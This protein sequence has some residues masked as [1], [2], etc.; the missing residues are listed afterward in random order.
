M[1]RLLAV[2]A[3]LLTLAAPPTIVTV[4][5][6]AFASVTVTALK[7]FGE[8][9]FKPGFTHFPHVNPDAP[10]GGTVTLAESQPG[11][12]DSLNTLIL[13]GVRPRT[14]GLI[15][16]TLMVG[17]GWELDAA[18][19]HL[20]ESVEVADD[21]G[22]AVFT[23]RQG[24]RW[25]DGVPVTAADVVFTW[26]AIQ[27]H[28]APFIKSFLDRIAKVE[29]LDE[30]R[31]RITLNG[32]GEIKPI[33]DFAVTLAPQPRHWWT[34]QGRDISKTTLEAPLGSGPYRIAAVDPGRSITYE[35]VKD[36]WAK[37]LPTAR[38]FYNFDTVKDDF[39]RDDDVM[40]EAFKAG[41]YDFRG[42]YRAQR[43]TTGYDFPA[44]R[45]GRVLKLAVPSELPLGAQGFRLNTRRDKFADV[46]VREALALLF[47]FDWIQKN[48]LYGQYKRTLSNFP[49]S[50]FGAA[51]KPGPDELALLEPYR[52]RLAER[53]L[54][55][56]FT[57]PAG[58]G[59]G[60]NR[61][62][63]REATR[64]FKEAGWEVRN[65]R[66]T[67][68]KT[69][70]GMAIEF[71]DGTGALTRVIQPYVETLRRVGIDATLRIVD[72]AQFQART[73]EFDFDAIIV[74]MNFFT[75]PG[76][77]LRGYFGS[78]AAGIKGSSNYSGIHDPVADALIDKALA[79]KDLPAVEAATRALDR[80]LLWGFYMVPHWYNPENWIAHRAWLAHPAVWPKY[81]QDY[82]STNFPATW[83]V[84]AAKKAGAQP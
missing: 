31:V 66:L 62:Q 64:L 79:A 30:R 78:A 18:Y 76:T 4:T 80:V 53:V 43:W 1:R 44:A 21:Y 13:R 29:A 41:A 15:S 47:D 74:N 35:R 14:L 24:A 67:N 52:D 57:L 20:A 5:G 32:A 2:A 61:A 12:Y 56:P 23:L 37:D 75:P 42:E 51:G 59:S 68:V 83:W 82:R 49:N 6:P 50:E 33:I 55:Q 27:A 58:D 54:T 63:V 19:A 38:G 17:S 26:D 69:G 36:W 25:H 65:G 22:W 77:E 11:T 84:D 34:A 8:P 48:I 39:Y 40:F 81:D 16:D 10:K 72:T 45:D 73:D 9:E 70:E 60:N 7:Q 71:L 3:T 28:G 46:R